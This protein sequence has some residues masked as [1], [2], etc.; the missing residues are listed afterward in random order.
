VIDRAGDT[1]DNSIGAAAG[2][3]EKRAVRRVVTAWIANDLLWGLI[4]A[5]TIRPYKQA[6]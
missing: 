5:S 3:A 6:R 4:L 1:P 2:A